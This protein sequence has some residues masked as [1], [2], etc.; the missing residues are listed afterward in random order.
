MSPKVSWF[1]LRLAAAAVAAAG[2]SVVAC[3]SALTRAT[4]GVGPQPERV[5]TIGSQAELVDASD[6]R[7]TAAE[8]V[9]TAITESMSNLEL[10]DRDGL[11][12]LLDVLATYI[13]DPSDESMLLYR[14][15]L[16]ARGASLH[17]PRCVSL[18][19]QH[20]RWFGLNSDVDRAE[21]DDDRLFLAV[22]SSREQRLM[23]LQSVAVTVGTN[24]ESFL[25]LPSPEW[26]FPGA[27][28]SNALHVPPDG[29]DQTTIEQEQDGPR[30][31]SVT[32]S[33]RF[34]DGSRGLLRVNLF[35]FDSGWLPVTFGVAS[36]SPE[37]W[38]WPAG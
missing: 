35:R 4:V 3:H 28:A 8:K 22:N 37:K 6:D 7:E 31:A 24:R 2:W 19:E 13:V 26:P 33:V 11:N 29:V 14:S 16:V 36:E 38:P 32:L 18:C 27:N 9:Y 5:T 20:D 10:D 15:V 17:R 21:L 25:S 34:G 23:N 12:S 30:C 1:R